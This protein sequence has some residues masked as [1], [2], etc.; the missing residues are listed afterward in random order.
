MRTSFLRRA[1]IRKK[2]SFSRHIWKFRFY[3]HIWIRWFCGE[4]ECKYLI[5]LWLKDIWFLDMRMI[6]RLTIPQSNPDL[7][8]TCRTLWQ[9][10]DFWNTLPQNNWVFLEF[11]GEEQDPLSIWNSEWLL[12]GCT[13][14]DV[15]ALVSINL[16]KIY[17]MEVKLGHVWEQ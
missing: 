2:L 5:H 9:Q 8:R 12:H 11:L 3:R 17:Y 10:S 6:R 16:T 14:L 13:Y 4:Y 1:S 7:A 15:I